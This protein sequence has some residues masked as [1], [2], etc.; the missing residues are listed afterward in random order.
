MRKTKKKLE[1]YWDNLIYQHLPPVAKFKKVN[2]EFIEHFS[3]V[4]WT[5]KRIILPVAVFYIIMG[6]I[7]KVN[8]FGVLLTSILI[9]FY[10]NFLPDIDI[11]FKKTKRKYL[12]SPWYE[13]CAVLFFAPVIFYDILMG[14]QR[15]LY[16]LN[17]RPFHNFKSVVIYGLFLFVVASVFWP[18]LLRRS[19]FTLF[20]MLG[21]IIHL[22]VD[23]GYSVKI[24]HKHH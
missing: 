10:S 3:F 5:L 23:W 15:Q 4:Q 7:F 20:G 21:Y 19:V 17:S 8:I 13:K 1:S 22:A 14:R 18:D 16:S 24:F 9:F 12:D 11:L 6:V 2:E